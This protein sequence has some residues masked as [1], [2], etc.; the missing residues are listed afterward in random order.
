MK[1][2]TGWIGWTEAQVLETSMPV[3]EAA[4]AGRV[5]MLRAMP[6]RAAASASAPAEQPAEPTG[7]PMTSAL[8]QA[9]FG[10]KT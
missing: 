8:F 4:Y 2:G 3:I 7:P 9:M 1:I 10:R 5:E 6:G